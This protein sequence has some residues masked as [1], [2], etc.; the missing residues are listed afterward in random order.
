MR[1]DKKLRTR[2]LDPFAKLNY[3]ELIKIKREKELVFLV[4]FSILG[5]KKKELIE[6]KC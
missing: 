3:M 5:F 2:A 4:F 6:M 1:I